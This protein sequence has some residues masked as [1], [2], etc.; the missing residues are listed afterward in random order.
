VAMRITGRSK[1]R[2]A[3]MMFTKKN[4]VITMLGYRCAA[5]RDPRCGGGSCT[6]HCR[7][8]SCEGSCLK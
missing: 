1:D 2:C 7:Y 6:F 5:R 8:G 4:D 3:S